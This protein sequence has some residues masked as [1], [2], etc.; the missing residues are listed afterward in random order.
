VFFTGLPFIL[1][2]QYSAAIG[3]AIGM[4]AGV[5]NAEILF[6]QT[7]LRG[8]RICPEMPEDAPG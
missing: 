4:I 1:L 8:L 3:E 5:G 2:A 6:T 7:H